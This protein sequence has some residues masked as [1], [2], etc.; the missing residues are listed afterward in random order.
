[1]RECTSGAASV[2]L[3]S[4]EMSLKG[5]RGKSVDEQRMLSLAREGEV[6]AFEALIEGYED[7]IY[8]LAFRMLGNSEDA[9]DAAQETLLKAYS[10][11]QRFRGDASF[12]TWIYRIAKNV[13]L[14]ILR[15]RSKQRTYSL[16]EPM[17][18]GDG[19]VSRQFAGDMPAPEDVVMHG[20]VRDSIN[21]ALAEISEHH[22]VVIILRDI[23]G[24][25]YE[26]IANILEIE[27]GTV[28][29]R[30]YRARASLHEILSEMELFRDRA[31]GQSEGGD[32][33]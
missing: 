6:A 4:D 14:D 12:S 16:D 11:L 32:D 26:E 9:R 13:C 23:E 15:R 25:T 27:L 24:F 8:S 1:M 5:T 29:S 3:N 18:L 7:K 30:L 10:G 22:R 33:G 28:K 2:I 21:S 31:V 19:E 17:E 20:E